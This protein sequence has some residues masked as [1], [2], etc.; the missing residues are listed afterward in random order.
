MRRADA[1]SLDLTPALRKVQSVPLLPPVTAAAAPA[2]EL[3]D[4][5]KEN[6]GGAPANGLDKALRAER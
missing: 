6:M 2:D 1:A 3:G 5:N 4:E